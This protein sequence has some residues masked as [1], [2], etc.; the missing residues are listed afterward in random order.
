MLSI[1]PGITEMTVVKISSDMPLPTPRSVISSPSHMMTAVPAVM[2][3]TIVVIVKMLSL[4][5]SDLV[6][7]TPWKSLPDL[8]RATMPV[9][10]R[11]ARPTVRYRVYWVILACPVWP[12]LRSVSSR[13]MTTASSC[14]MML[15]VMYGMMPSAKTV[16]LVMEPPLNRLSSWNRLVFEAVAVHVRMA[17]SET[18]GVGSCWPSRNT[19]MM[20]IV[21]SSFLRRSGVLNALK[22]AVSMR[23]PLVDRSPSSV[24]PV[25]GQRRSRR[26][27]HSQSPRARSLAA[28]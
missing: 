11:M 18:P 26:G 7:L 12:S 24:A 17:D 20:K 4:T 19:A 2:Q 14:R 23:H 3:I 13:G 1:S 25:P 16:S 5:S 9:D 27:T 6:Q 22:N 15:A 28:V 21:N 10:W 8:A